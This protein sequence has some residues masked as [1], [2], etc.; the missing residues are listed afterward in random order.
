LANPWGL[1]A[2]V[3]LPLVLYLHRRATALRR[4]VPLVRLWA[5]APAGEL[6]GAMRRR[7]DPIL[8]V[9]LLIVTAIAV[10]LAR[11]GWPTREPARHIFVFDASASM[12]TREAGRLRFHQALEAA[13]R[14]LNTLPAGDAVL[15][16]RAGTP[17]TVVH[18]FSD[19]RGSL[20][21][22]MR[23]LA[24]GEARKNLGAALAEAARRFGEAAAVVHV[25]SDV[26]DEARLRR[27][28]ARVGLPEDAVRLHRVGGLADN[29]AIVALDGRPA[30]GSP[31]D[32]EIFSEVANFSARARVVDVDLYGPEGLRARRRL[33]LAAAERRGVAFLTAGA[34]W[35]EIRLDGVTDA[36]PVDD[37]AVLVLPNT[38]LRVLYASR[39]DRFVE[40]ALRAHPGVRVRRIPIEALAAESGSK[41]T[42]QVAVIDGARVPRDFPLPALILSATENREGEALVPIADWQRRHPIL[43]ELD[44]GEALVPAG[45]VLAPGAALIRSSEGPVV[46]TTV[47]GGVPRVEIAFSVRHSTLGEMPA[48]PILVARALDWL[49]ADVVTRPLNLRAGETADSALPGSSREDAEIHRPDGSIV[50]VPPHGSHV[51]IV[52]TDLVGRYEVTQGD[53]RVPFAVNLLDAE[54]SNVD[55]ATGAVGS[56]SAALE[57]THPR[58]GW[59]DLARWIL[60]IGLQ[61]LSVEIWLLQRGARAGAGR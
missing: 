34:P 44:L 9:R 50:R 55:R 37:R 28:A 32:H 53:L 45:A 15:V 38:P 18:D 4:P 7:L 48:F 20:R 26:R 22:A 16:L 2:L 19:D 36:L 25:F 8:L 27:L 58:T 49:A 14:A 59:H 42:E 33:A 61:L 47:A 10:A 24:A 51:A 5:P 13:D 56:M 29:V 21:T 52:R 46:R 31:V 12:L 11:P 57:G 41:L 60:A 39:G 6:R 17:P 35:V 43:R 23:T 30:A 3:A 40:A 54:E 1:L